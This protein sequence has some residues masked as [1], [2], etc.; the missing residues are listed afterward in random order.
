[1]IN[2]MIAGIGRFFISLIF[3]TLGISGIFNWDIAKSELS[4]ALANWELYTGYIEGV[5]FV[6]QNLISASPLIVVLGIVIQ[7][8][9][10]FMLSLSLKSRLAAM[11]LLLQIVPATILYFH[12]WFL[13]GPQMTRNMILFIK[14]LSIIGGLLVVIS[15]M[16]GDQAFEK[17]SKKAPQE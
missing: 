6:I 3:I 11:L 4:S 16:A 9:G 5:S 10:G 13:D 14:N 15:S 8:V 12:F 1:M 2:K 7:L 17:P